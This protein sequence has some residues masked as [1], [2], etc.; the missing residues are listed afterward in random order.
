MSHQVTYFVFNK[1]AG[2][3]VAKCAKGATCEYLC[4]RDAENIALS[5][6]NIGSRLSVDRMLTIY[7][8]M[9]ESPKAAFQNAETAAKETWAAIVAAFEDNEFNDEEYSAAV[10]DMLSAQS[11]QRQ[12]KTKPK[13]EDNM[14]KKKAAKKGAPKG[15]TAKAAPKGK[16]AKASTGGGS[17]RFSADQKI[18]LLCEGNPYREGTDAFENFSKIKKSGTTVGDYLKAGGS[19]GTLRYAMNRGGFIKIT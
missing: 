5:Q 9:V 1:K 17:K 16:T 14:G 11:N 10:A 6:E 7:N 12:P 4:V 8:Q 15:K 13:E 18:I 2:E 3:F 19:T